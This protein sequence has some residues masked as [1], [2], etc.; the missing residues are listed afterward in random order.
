MFA[1]CLYHCLCR[2]PAALLVV[3]TYDRHFAVD[4]AVEGDN[5]F[6]DIIVQTDFQR[7]TTHDNSMIIPSIICL[8]SISTIS[9]SAFSLSIVEH[10]IILYPCLY[11]AISKALMNVPKNGCATSG[12]MMPIIFVQLRNRLRAS[13]FGT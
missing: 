6:V 8:C 2:Q 1:A 12:T 13:S 3:G 9:C 4:N 7:M 5:R 11:K 10:T